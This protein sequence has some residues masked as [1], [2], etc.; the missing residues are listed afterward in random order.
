MYSRLLFIRKVLRIIYQFL[1]IWMLFDFI[2][3][4]FQNSLLSLK[5]I[6]IL[7]G[8]LIVSYIFRDIFSHGIFLFIIHILSGAGVYFLVD[9]IFTRVLMILAVFAGVVCYLV[10]DNYFRTEEEPAADRKSVV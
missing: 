4:L 3:A 6:G 7:A 2:K 8:I 9:D 1:F 5:D 10:Y